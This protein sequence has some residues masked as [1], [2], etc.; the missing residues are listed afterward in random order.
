MTRRTQQ[1]DRLKT[2][3]I[4]TYIIDERIELMTLGVR[5]SDYSKEIYA[6]VGRPAETPPSTI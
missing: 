3:Y 6:W 1:Y 4:I 5:L 2:Y